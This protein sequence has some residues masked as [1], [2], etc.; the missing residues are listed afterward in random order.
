MKTELIG[1]K[2]T[3]HRETLAECLTDVNRTL[4]EAHWSEIAPHQDISLDPDYD[5]YFRLEEA[6]CLRIYTLRDDGVTQGYAVFIVLPNMKYRHSLQATADLLYL[7]PPLRK[8]MLG[9]R[10]VQ[11]CDEQLSREGVQIV[12]HSVERTYDFS[13]LLERL[14]YEQEQTVYCRRLDRRP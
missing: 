4:L 6:K 7:V 5:A 2:I 1:A 3:F 9:A 13:S 8:Q 11:W 10:F 12:R 14:G